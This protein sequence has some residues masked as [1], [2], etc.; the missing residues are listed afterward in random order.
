LLVVSVV[1]EGADEFVPAGL[2]SSKLNLDEFSKPS[3]VLDFL[4]FQLKVGEETSNVETA[5]KT[6]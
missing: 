3:E 2:V 6:N 5:F 1:A 4:F